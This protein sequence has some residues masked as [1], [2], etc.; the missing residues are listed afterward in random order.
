MIV[1]R[2]CSAKMPSKTIK[3]AVGNLKRY[4]PNHYGNKLYTCYPNESYT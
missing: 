2:E 4:I 3:Q 1:F